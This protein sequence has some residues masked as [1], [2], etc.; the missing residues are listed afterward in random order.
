MEAPM[1]P[2]ETAAAVKARL[3]ESPAR[4]LVRR[5]RAVWEDPNGDMDEWGELV[6]KAEALG[7]TS[8]DWKLIDVHR[9][10]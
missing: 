7:A 6:S 5:A 2:E 9:N 10:A 1:T 4:Q 8:E 3:T